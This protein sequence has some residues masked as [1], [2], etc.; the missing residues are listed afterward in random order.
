MPKVLVAACVRREAERGVH[1]QRLVPASVSRF[2]ETE[3]PSSPRRGVSSSPARRTWP[4]GKGRGRYGP[5]D[6]GR[7]T[8]TLDRGTGPQRHTASAATRSRFQGS[9]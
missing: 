5:V 4:Q 9:F 6:R 2:L 1:E 3:P 8:G 7:S